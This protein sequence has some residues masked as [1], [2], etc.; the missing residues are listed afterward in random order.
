MIV[1]TYYFGSQII[2]TEKRDTITEFSNHVSLL[3]KNTETQLGSAI[4]IIEVTRTLPIVKSINYADHISEEYKGIPEDMDLKKRTLAKQILKTYPEF[5]FITFHIPNGDFYIMEPYMDQLNVTRLNF[6]DRD[7]YRGVMSTED[8]YVS[9]V[10]NSTTLKRNVVAIRTPVFDDTGALL[11]IWGGSLKLQF[12]QESV[13]ELT[14]GK[15][16]RVIFYDQYGTK[17]LDTSSITEQSFPSY[18]IDDVL[19]GKTD[20]VLVDD[21]IISYRPIQAG[22]TTWGLI[23]LQPQSDAFFSALITEGIIAFMLIIFSIILAFAGYFIYKITQKNTRLVKEIQQA[24]IQKEEFSAMITHE[25]KTPLVPIL[26]HAKML[27]KKD[28]IGNL[29]EEQLDSVQVI[30]RNANRLEK[31]INDIMDARKLDIDKMKFDIDNVVLDEFLANLKSNYQEIL[32]KKDIE[33]VL[34]NQTQGIILNT[35]ADRV[36]QVFGNLISNSIKFVPSEKGKIIVGA[37][38]KDDFVQF[39]VKDNGIGISKDKQSNLFQK[40][41]QIDTTHTRKIQGTGLGLVICKGIIEKIGGKIWVESD[42]KNGSTFF[43]T[44]P[45]KR[46]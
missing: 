23:I 8:T 26:G 9:E 43:F 45:I 41:Y 11:G 25:L 44:L 35:D 5:E 2:E 28:M 22:S 34:D 13:K 24:S 36:R 37:T 19:S 29:N 21:L 3:A 40:F 27:S 18:F 1:T 7:W 17:I 20:T 42:G 10:Y 31:L 33:F 39:H 6:A 12:I 4:N 15:N 46:A 38:I 30:E 32:N 16:S 14:L